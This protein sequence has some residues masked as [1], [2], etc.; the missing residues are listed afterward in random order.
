MM[1][2]DYS[3]ASSSVLSTQHPHFLLERHHIPLLLPLG[4]SPTCASPF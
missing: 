1:A 2:S 4:S 3:T